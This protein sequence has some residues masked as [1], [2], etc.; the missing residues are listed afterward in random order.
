[1]A[2]TNLLHSIIITSREEEQISTD[3]GAIQVIP[4]WKFL[5]NFSNT[6]PKS[7]SEDG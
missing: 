1:M 7:L 2:E 3:H 6:L 5:L 4:L